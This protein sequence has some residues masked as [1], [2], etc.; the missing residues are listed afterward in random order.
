MKN[1]R[2]F[3]CF[4]ICI[5]F[6]LQN[7]ESGWGSDETTLPAA[8]NRTSFTKSLNYDISIESGE[9]REI[10]ESPITPPERALTVPEWA[11]KNLK[12]ATRSGFWTSDEDLASA[13]HERMKNVNFR[14]SEGQNYWRLNHKANSKIT[15]QEYGVNYQKMYYPKFNDNFE[16]N[17]QNMFKLVYPFPKEGAVL[18]PSNL[19]NS[20]GVVWI[21]LLEDET[22]WE[23]LY[24]REN[25]T[26]IHENQTELIQFLV[27]HIEGIP[28][29]NHETPKDW[30]LEELAKP[31]P[32]EHHPLEIRVVAFCGDLLGFWLSVKSMEYTECWR[33]DGKLDYHDQQEFGPWNILKNYWGNDAERK[34]KKLFED[35]EK[36]YFSF[37]PFEMSFLPFVRMDFFVHNET[38]NGVWTTYNEGLAGMSFASSHGLENIFEE[39][40]LKFNEDKV[41]L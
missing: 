9:Q 21:K 36:L 29:A 16:E 33:I 19:M 10:D 40:H 14:N 34:F 20:I 38:R 15:L 31:M 35:V 1:K 28:A 27:R 12:F 32:L 8:V 30:I 4:Y 17:I 23:T 3:F 5:A 7:V 37:H 26:I 25:E 13:C 18:K 24:F 39:N 11:E 6:F 2:M 41:E 22:R